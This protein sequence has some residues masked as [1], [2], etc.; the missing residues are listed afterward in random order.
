MKKI[1]NCKTII[2]ITIK[3]CRS[4]VY[5]KG[6]IRRAMHALSNLQNHADNSACYNDTHALNKKL[7]CA[8]LLR[9][10]RDTITLR[11]DWQNC[12]C[13]ESIERDL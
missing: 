13:M 2:T 10:M 4:L 8:G 6:S 1:N 11:G 9:I 12:F 5:E 3:E 7:L